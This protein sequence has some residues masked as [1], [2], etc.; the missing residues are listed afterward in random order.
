VSREEAVPQPPSLGPQSFVPK[1]LMTPRTIE[2]VIELRKATHPQDVCFSIFKGAVG[3]VIGKGGQ[4]L[5]DM[6]TDFGVRVFV[7]KEDFGGKRLVVLS[8]TGHGPDTE[9]LG[10]EVAED[11]VRRCQ[12]HIEEIVQDSVNRQTQAEAIGVFGVELPIAT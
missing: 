10:P 12:A 2:T 9:A 1:T 5:K 4:N 11:A 8:Y 6:L 3:A 7:E